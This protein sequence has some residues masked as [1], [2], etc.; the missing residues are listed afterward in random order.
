M[1]Y[2]SEEKSKIVERYYKGES[3]I[4]LDIG[5]VKSIFS[6]GLNH[7]RRWILKLKLVKRRLS[8]SK[9]KD[10]MSAFKKRLKCGKLIFHS[11][12]GTPYDPNS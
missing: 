7:R 4:C 1:K 5:F 8:L 3:A 6:L 10:V 12:R 11:D 9:Q 2:S